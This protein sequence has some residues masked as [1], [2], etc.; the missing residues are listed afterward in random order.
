[1]IGFLRRVTAIFTVAARRLMSNRWLTLAGAWG[2]TVVAVFALCVPL[3]A[4]A[5]YH[6]V[7]L[8]ELGAVRDDG[9]RLPS[10]AFVFRD[11]V[12]WQ[13]AHM[14]QEIQTADQFIDQQ[15]PWMLQ[16][17]RKT[18]IR[19]LQSAD[20]RL[21]PATAGTYDN[22]K[23]SLINLPLTSVSSFSD[24]IR[25]TEGKLTPDFQ[26]PGMSLTEAARQSDQ[27]GLSQPPLSGTL[28]TL[29][30]LVSRPMA[31][32]LGMQVGD[33][34][35]AVA[36]PMGSVPLTVPVVIAGVWEPRDTHEPYWFYKPYRMGNMLIISEQAFTQRLAPQLIRRFATVLWYSDFDGRGVRVWDVPAM[37]ARID[38]IVTRGKT[39]QLNIGLNV[40][41]LDAL[42]RYQ[43]NSQ[44]LISHLY[45]FSIP[46]YV[47][48]FA[49][50]VLVAGLTTNDQRNEVAV[51]RSRGASV[52]QVLG[53]A[54]AQALILG[55][56][57]LLIG[58]PLAVGVVQVLGQARSFLQFGGR[59]LLPV[60][61]TSVGIPIGVAAIGMTILITALPMLGPSRHTVVTYKQ[62]RARELR[63]P[64][65][66]R[67]GLDFLLLIPAVYWTYMLQKQGTLDLFATIPSGDGSSAGPFGNPSLFLVPLLMMLALTLVFIRVLPTLLRFLSWLSAWL[68]G[69]SVVLALRQLART[70]QLYATPVLLLTL[71][72]AMAAFTS[73]VAATLDRH[74]EQQTQYDI[75]ADVKLLQTGQEAGP[76]DTLAWFAP[77]TQT[78]SASTGDTSSTGV[79]PTGPRWRFLPVTEYLKAPD[80]LAASRVGDYE[81]LVNFSVGGGQGGRFLGVDRNDLPHVAFWRS[82]FADQPLMGLMNMLAATP[83][84]VLV[85]ESTLR[86]NA[87]QV[88][89]R[90]RVTLSFPDTKAEADMDVQIVGAFKLWPTWY[91]YREGT[92]PVFIGNLDYIFDMSGGQM[93]YDVWLKTRPGADPETVIKEVHQVDNGLW[94]YQDVR[95]LIEAEQLQP[96]RQGLFGMLSIGFIASAL[97]T[98]FGFVLYAVF[99]YRRRFIEFGILRAI[100]FDVRQMMVLLGVELALL[101]VCGLVGGTALGVWAS[102]FYIPFLQGSISDQTRAVPFLIIIDWARI[103]LIYMVF[104]AMFAASMVALVVFLRRLKVFQAIKLGETI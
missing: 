52:W 103:D 38:D 2:T 92:G 42:A 89:D 74:L 77:P 79:T 64:L 71:T 25:L 40:S 47:L 56:V 67:I 30:V 94:K 35:I 54:F 68:P 39:P 11:G 37:I 83:D 23:D 48:A 9:P 7:L 62:E 80:V 75:G 99:S 44:A 13:Q 27:L 76:G 24:H 63:P 3:Y 87:L 49:F 45:V 66:Q 58:I 93:P 32:Q 22:S 73:S 14:W 81:M 16:L 8:E 28:G 15:L 53:I 50:V 19:Y 29:N 90:L 85:P 96:Q 33:H 36:D 72:L 10:F 31:D 21:Y 6:R 41:P 55:I 104:G 82:D 88:G 61:V 69:T 65:W 97:L 51:L 86:D 12:Y 102:Q 46:L 34:Y 59:E 78:S 5:V 18:L 4:D 70:P 57:G 100:G 26:A 1:M 91:P 95:S 20:F 43:T 60:V 17:P 98:L 84:G 101:L